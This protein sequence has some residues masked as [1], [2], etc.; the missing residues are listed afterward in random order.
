MPGMAHLPLPGPQGAVTC[1]RRPRIA[2]IHS[3]HIN[4]RGPTEAPAKRNGGVA[5]F[6]GIK[7]LS[8]LDLHAGFQLRQIQKVAAVDRQ[9]FNLTGTQYSLHRCL[10]G[11]DLK[12]TGLHIDDR[13]LLPY[14]EM[15]VSVRGV[16]HQHY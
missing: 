14:L 5:D 13:A 15:Y 10:L 11:V 3:I 1:A 4:A 7:I 6:R 9:S 12:L 16:A 8:V 2:Y